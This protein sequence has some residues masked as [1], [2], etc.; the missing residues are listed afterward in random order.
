MAC[1]DYAGKIWYSNM[2]P[3]TLNNFF[4]AV[5]Q[6][7][8]AKIITALSFTMFAHVQNYLLPESVD[9]LLPTLVD[10]KLP[11]TNDLEHKGVQRMKAAIG[12]DAQIETDYWA[13]PGETAK[14][15]NARVALREFAVRWWV[16]NLK[17]ETDDWLRSHEGGCA[18]D[19]EAI[20]DCLCRAAGADYWE[21]HRG[22]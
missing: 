13:M 16:L 9:E 18:L 7:P 5:L 3:S 20:S 10:S 14:E 12:D 22:G 8:P 19:R 17:T 2:Q 1:W 11:E 4:L 6:S 15:T 21:W